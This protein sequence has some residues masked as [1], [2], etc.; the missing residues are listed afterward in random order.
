MQ[1]QRNQLFKCS[2]LQSLI[3][4]SVR[5]VFFPFKTE[6]RIMHMNMLREERLSQM[7][8]KMVSR[9]MT[10]GSYFQLEIWCFKIW[11]FSK[12]RFSFS[13]LKPDLGIHFIIPIKQI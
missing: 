1:N 10:Q 5:S 8:P 4:C 9:P 11:G 7:Q 13:F 6:Y 3:F 2:E 12:F